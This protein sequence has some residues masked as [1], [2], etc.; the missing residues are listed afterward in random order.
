MIT[1]LTGD[2]SFELNQALEVLAQDFAGEIERIDGSELASDRLIE[3]F[4]GSSLY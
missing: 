1:L 4:S 2:N 3:L